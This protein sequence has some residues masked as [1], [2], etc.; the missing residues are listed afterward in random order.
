LNNDNQDPISA[1]N[2]KT[3]VITVF[4]SPFKWLRAKVAGQNLSLPLAL[5]FPHH[6][7]SWSSPEVGP[8]IIKFLKT[9]FKV[10]TPQQA[11]ASYIATGK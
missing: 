9:H 5:Q 10:K 2:F 1:G 4:K 11:N 3:T 8:P 6:D 7:Y